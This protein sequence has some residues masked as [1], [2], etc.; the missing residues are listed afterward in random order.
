M[1]CNINV[2]KNIHISA[3]FIGDRVYSGTIA[4]RLGEK[5][6]CCPRRFTCREKKL[7]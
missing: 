6:C 2:L 3:I 5:K 7:H 4:D 1:V